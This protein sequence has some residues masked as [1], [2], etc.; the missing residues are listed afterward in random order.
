MTQS[1]LETAGDMFRRAIGLHAND[2][3]AWAGLATV[4]ATL[5]E[6]FG[7]RE[8]DL[9]QAERASEQAWSQDA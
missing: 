9:A 6:W 4:H 5:D 7:A 1:D 3:P 8:D 2:G